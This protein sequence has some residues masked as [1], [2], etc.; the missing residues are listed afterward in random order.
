MFP[1]IRPTRLIKRAL[2]WAY[3]ALS[4]EVYCARQVAS[5]RGNAE[6]LERFR[7]REILNERFLALSLTIGREDV[8]HPE[9]AKADARVAQLMRL[10]GDHLM[11][12][13]R[14]RAVRRLEILTEPPA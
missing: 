4:D 7:R 14:G 6:T 12:I 1:E 11:I 13:L 3:L 9:A 5:G 2:H 10:R 8:D